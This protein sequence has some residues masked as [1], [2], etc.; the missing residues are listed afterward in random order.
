ML[1]V[2]LHDIGE[3]I[4]EGEI[5]Q[6]L[7]KEGEQVA[8]D[9]PL[10]EIQTDK[11]VAEL[12]APS[13]GIVKKILVP[14][15]QSVQVGT[16]IMY[17]ETLKPK[18][19]KRVL[20]TPYTR[21]LAREHQ[22]NLEDV[23]AS[24]PSGRV[25]E[26]DV[27]RFIKERNQQQEKKH[28]QLEQREPALQ[29][30][31]KKSADKDPEKEAVPPITEETLVKSIPFRGIRKQIA[32]KMSQSMYTIPHVT[33]FE[34]VD[35]TNLLALK[36]TLKETDHSI[37]ITAFLVKALVQTLKEF[38]IFNAELDEKNEQIILKQEY[39]IG[40]ATDTQDGLL[41][42][43]LRQADRK[44]IKEM[45]TEIKALTEKAKNGSLS[46]ADLQNS[47]FTISNVGPLGGSLFATPIINYPETALIA[48]HQI[49]KR[50]V[51]NEQDQ[52][53]VRQIMTLSFSFDHRVADGATAISFIKRFSMLIEQPNTLL[54]ELI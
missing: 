22:I 11:V 3:G 44:S 39:N 15:G 52:I 38:P 40:L 43:V 42:P 7:V 41:V 21:K 50:P 24:D 8:S 28:E 6:Y 49:K 2:K 30:Q 53:V 33:T 10:V 17:I 16:T 14:P 36:K 34:E 20:A 35:L 45:N 13:S 48:F 37:S 46:P 5:I 1:E 12:P 32:Q 51:V 19:Y 9:Q 25:T 29:G 23:P 4:T 47:T 18:S 31:Q 26:E 27:Y 54:L